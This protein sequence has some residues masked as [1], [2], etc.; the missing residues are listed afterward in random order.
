MS[1]DK[2]MHT[3]SK[4]LHLK[5]GLNACCHKEGEN[6]IINNGAHFCTVSLQRY[7]LCYSREV[8]TALNKKE[9]KILYVFSNSVKWVCWLEQMFQK[10]V[11]QF[12]HHQVYSMF[13]KLSMIQCHLQQH[14]V[15]LQCTSLVVRL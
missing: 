14:L 11:L 1:K 5:A 4:W 9:V 15:S 2:I 6:M 8:T 3:F 7:S 13:D 12:R 10:I